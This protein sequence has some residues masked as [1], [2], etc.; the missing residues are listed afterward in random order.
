VTK[1]ITV[2][3]KRSEL[4]LSTC[5]KGSRQICDQLKIGNFEGA[6]EILNSTIGSLYICDDENRFAVSEL[7]DV[8]TSNLIWD[9]FQTNDIRDLDEI[10]D[11]ALLGIPNFSRTTLQR[12][13]S[14]IVELKRNGVW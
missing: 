7:V 8:R 12:I 11:A 2:R 4:Y 1:E 14:V 5:D 6:I 3:V 10:E 9:N 13:R